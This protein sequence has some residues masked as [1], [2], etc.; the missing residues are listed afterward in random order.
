MYTNY[1]TE[2]DDAVKIM[3]LSSSTSS[4]FGGRKKCE[5]PEDEEDEMLDD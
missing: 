1:S 3:V 2:K 5:M 4:N